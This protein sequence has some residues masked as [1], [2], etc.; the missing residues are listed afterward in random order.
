MRVED[1]LNTVVGI[2]GAVVIGGGILYYPIS[3]FNSQDTITATVLDKERVQD[4]NS[5]GCTSKYLIFTDRETL[6]NTDSLPFM[7]FNSSDVQGSITVGNT[8]QF[9][10]AGWRIPFFSM[11]RN[12][13]SA[14]ETVQQQA[15]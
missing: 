1:V 3:Y 11:Y 2:G 8:Y 4:C 5:E 13:L 7:K 9:R 6:E 12:I 10:V 14:Q 15:N